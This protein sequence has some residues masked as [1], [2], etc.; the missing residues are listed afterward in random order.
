MFTTNTPLRFTRVQAC[1]LAGNVASLPF[2]ISREVTKAD[3]KVQTAWTPACMEEVA[4]WT[5]SG[6][7][8][9]WTSSA[10]QFAF[11]HEPMK[12]SPS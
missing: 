6:D 11:A 8:S 4:S 1:F 7:V 12:P 9:S 2:F 3:C 10:V 5:V